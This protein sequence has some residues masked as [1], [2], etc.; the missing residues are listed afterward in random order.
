[1]DTAIVRYFSAALQH[2][3]SLIKFGVDKR[4]IPSSPLTLIALLRAVA[5]R[6]LATGLSRAVDAD[7]KTAAGKDED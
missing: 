6:D 5:S 4:V 3:P 1:M 7:N 2:D